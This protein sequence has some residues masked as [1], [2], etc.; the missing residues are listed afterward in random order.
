[1]TDTLIKVENVSKKFCRDLK[2]SLWYGVRDIVGDL[3]GS[4][5]NESAVLRKQEFWALREVSLHLGRGECM[6]LIGHNGAGKSTLLKMLNGLI[7]PDGGR[8]EISG[9]VGSLIELTAGFNPILTGRENVYVNGA[10][11]GLSKREIDRK[12]DEIVEFAEI[13]DFI[14]APVKNY[15][16]GM[17][18]RLGFAVAI[19]MDPDVLLID[20]VLAVGDVGFRMKCLD[21]IGRM[22]PKVAVVFVSHIMPQVARI[23]NKVLLLES[24]K[25]AY[26]GDDVSK[27]IEEYF[28]M[29]DTGMST[30]AGN[31]KV[32]VLEL[33]MEGTSFSD[34]V[35]VVKYGSMVR[36]RL[37]LDVSESV[38]TY[39]V[40]YSFV[41]KDTKPVA[42][43]FSLLSGDLFSS[44]GRVLVESVIDNLILGQGIYQVSVAINEVR[45]D[46]TRGE[47]YY[48][49][50]NAGI[51]NVTGIPTGLAPVQFRGSWGI[52]EQVQ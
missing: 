11:L 29:F 3:V 5:K 18:V 7:K 37:A 33:T 13:R 41:D 50:S 30:I 10:V 19:Q 43:F 4:T 36:F 15:S 52:K 20:E 49:N 16:S 2:R 8:I 34:G 9:R 27:G 31:G 6:G 47:I 45:S 21:A 1:M 26:Y 38:T 32:N 51:L 48:F 46:G 44:K 40:N 23:C 12:F 35:H 42:N 14:D 24:G 17:K 25:V 22:L 39:W 28:G